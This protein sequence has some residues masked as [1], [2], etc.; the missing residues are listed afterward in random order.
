MKYFGK[1]FLTLVGI[2]LVGC[3]ITSHPEYQQTYFKSDVSADQINEIA[4]LFRSNNLLGALIE[5]DSIGRVQLAGEFNNE[6]E[7]EKAF[8]IAER[9]VGAGNLSKA[10]PARVKVLNWELEATKEFTKY[11]QDLALRY[12]ISLAIE[13]DG[14]D[15]QINLNNQT[16]DGAEQFAFN[17]DTPSER[18]KEFYEHFAKGLF[19]SSRS[20]SISKKILI[21]GHTDDVGDSKFNVNLSERRARSIGKIFNAA[22]FLPGN[23]FYQGAGEIFPVGSNETAEGRLKNRRVEVAELADEEVLGLYDMSRRPKVSLYR[24][25]KAEEA[26]VGNATKSDAKQGGQR[27]RI[28]LS[29]NENQ[30]SEILK[31]ERTPARTDSPEGVTRSYTTLNFG[32]IP[33]SPQVAMLNLGTIE[34][35]KSVFSFISHAYAQ[36]VS[37]LND[38]T[39]DRPRSL[40]PVKSLDTGI[41]K[42]YKPTDFMKG[43]GGKS[44]YGN[45]NS[46]LMVLDNVYVLRENGES[47]VPT[48]LKAYA[49]Y[50]N[51]PNRKPDIDHASPV[52]SYLVGNG[53]LYRIFP[54]SSSGLGCIDVVFPS[55]GTKKVNQGVLVYS[56]RSGTFVAEYKPQLSD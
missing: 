24:F 12:K 26:I 25:K 1:I 3:A 42:G 43:L 29:G 15:K 41:P 11:I 52:N 9:V 17:S 7:V 16:L 5:R 14:T 20:L 37:S 56:S 22:G 32:G 8:S 53:I 50:D 21:V 38:C 10:R 39:K 4:R 23:I 55:N 34:N 30:S 36:D 51:N 47:P 18:A 2:Q 27:P 45:I 6:Y 40:G 54:P 28:T 31:S 13:T 46:Q 44:W 33:Y 35:R 19:E 48:R 49:N